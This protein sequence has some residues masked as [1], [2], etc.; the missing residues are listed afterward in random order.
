MNHLNVVINWT[1]NDYELSKI[2]R[3][4]DIVLSGFVKRKT[5]TYHRRVEAKFSCHICY[6]YK[7][8]DILKVIYRNVVLW[9]IFI[10]TMKIVLNNGSCLN[11]NR[12]MELLNQPTIHSASVLLEIAMLIYMLVNGKLLD[13]ELKI[14]QVQG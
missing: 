10:Y 1:F 2:L 8:L 3:P 9:T 12:M 5:E 11:F 7:Y 4:S 13:Q 6:E 14:P